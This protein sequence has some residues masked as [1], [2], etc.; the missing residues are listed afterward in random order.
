M[1]LDH[2]HLPVPDAI[3]TA[4]F[5]VHYFDLDRLPG[6]NRNF[7]ALTDRAEMVLIVSK[8]EAS[9]FPSGFIQPSEAAVDAIYERMSA[10]G[11]AVQPPAR[12]HAWTFYVEA[13][14][15]ITVEV[16]A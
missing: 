2:L 9:R 3:A 14:G 11:I 16:L 4:A 10:D 13:P 7:I 15:G 8:H 5:L 12:L 6:G 1:N